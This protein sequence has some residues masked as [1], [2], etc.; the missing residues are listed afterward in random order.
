MST[1]DPLVYRAD[2]GAEI[3][4]TTPCPDEPG[5]PPRCGCGCEFVRAADR[6]EPGMAADGRAAAGN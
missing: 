1:A 5:L 4:F 3:V 2:C 6:P